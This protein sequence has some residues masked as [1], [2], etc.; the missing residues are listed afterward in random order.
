MILKF[1]RHEF[2]HNLLDQSFDSQN[3][4]KH[5]EDDKISLKFQAIKLEIVRASFYFEGVK[6][7]ITFL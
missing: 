5:T 6:Y 3:H 4:N 1:L 7:L 2:D